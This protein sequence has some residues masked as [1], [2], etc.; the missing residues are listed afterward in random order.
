MKEVRRLKIEAKTQA[1]KDYLEEANNEKEDSKIFK[2]IRSLNGSPSSNNT[3]EA[4][5]IRN[6]VG[7][8]KT[9]TSDIRKADAF[10]D[11]YAA[12]SRHKFSK[13]ER[14][15]NR[16]A[17][18]VLSSKSPSPHSEACVDFSLQ[19]MNKALKKM[20]K[21]GAAGQDDIPVTFL[22]ALGPRAKTI[23]LS[24]LNFS[25][26]TGQIPQIWR[27]ATI[28]P[29]LKAAKPES[30]LE[31]YMPIALTS[32]VVKLFKRMIAN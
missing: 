19:E 18:K 11:H 24:I 13:E 21:K 6:G 28:I 30:K 7:K 3:N 22:V 32:C 17:K 9:I 16:Q 23:L 25:F 8:T 1:W 20:N 26:T 29:L 4:L 15:V 10:I 12:V 27:N 5:V 31:S 2:I 14:D